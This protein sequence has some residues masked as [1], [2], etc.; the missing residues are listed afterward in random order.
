MDIRR[1]LAYGGVLAVAL[2]AVLAAFL[3]VP[4]EDAGDGAAD[5]DAPVVARDDVPLEGATLAGRGDERP[6]RTASLEKLLEHLK[7]GEGD[8]YDRAV[9]ELRTRAGD[10]A[11]FVRL[12]AERLRNRWDWSVLQALVAIGAPAAVP[13]AELAVAADEA[14]RGESFWALAELGEEAASAASLLH[15]RLVSS[16][17]ANLRHHLITALGRIGPGASV[18][19]PTLLALLEPPLDD[20]VAGAAAESVAQIAGATPEVLAALRAVILDE[21][22]RSRPRAIAALAHL[23]PAAASLTPLLLDLL[24]DGEDATRLEAAGALGAMGEASPRVLDAL[25]AMLEHDHM[26]GQMAAA[27]ALVALGSGGL[28]AL[29]RTATQA[30]DVDVRLNAARVLMETAGAQEPLCTGLL[31]SVLE[32]DCDRGWKKQALACLASL[33]PPPPAA[34]V[35][36][37]LRACLDDPT[38]AEFA[39]RVLPRL[40]GEEARGLLVAALTGKDERGLEEAALDAVVSVP[41]KDPA[42]DALIADLLR[43]DRPLALV[44]ATLGRL[45]RLS[46]KGRAGVLLPALEPFFESDDVQLRADAYAALAWLDGDEAGRVRLLLEGL[47]DEPVAVVCLN[48]LLSFPRHAPTTLPAAVELVLSLPENAPQRPGATWTTARLAGRWTGGRAWLEARR[49]GASEAERARLDELL[50]RLR[51]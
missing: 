12:L 37:Q 28:A 10:D 11:D 1:T 49:E 14:Y 3:L 21:E 32:A 16:D 34:A 31:V 39:V 26:Q 47:H 27:R 5:G 18:A 41:S 15:E 2:A 48:G 36:P 23:G 43:P 4:R 51:D 17:D 7:A 24:E 45:R 30:E 46:P 29:T 40:G 22:T 13:L 33:D 50:T 6:L 20:D 35:L 25:A 8:D 9:T 42:R 44:R 38:L 19:V